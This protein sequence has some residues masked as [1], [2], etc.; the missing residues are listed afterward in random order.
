MTRS[1]HRV[2]AFLSISLLTLV[3]AC[4]ET[5]APPAYPTD[6]VAGSIAAASS[7]QMTGIVGTN[8]ATPPSVIV[9]DESGRP[10]AGATVRFSITAGGGQLSNSTAT[11][12]SQGIA[13]VA[14]WTLG[15]TV[16]SNTVIASLSTL[17]SIRFD[18]VTSPGAVAMILKVAGDDQITARGSVVPVRPQVKVMDAYFNPVKD[19]LVI[20]AIGAGGGSLTGENVTTNSL[21]IA[22]LGSWTLGSS[23]GQTLLAK[24]VELTPVTFQAITFETAEGCETVGAL[25]QQV[26]LVSELS[27]QGCQDGD[28]KFVNYYFVHLAYPAAWEFKLVS[29]VFAP[30]VELRTGNGVPVASG[31]SSALTKN[32]EINAILP[33]GDFI[34]VATS[35]EANATGRY[36]ISYEA[37]SSDAGECE[38]SIGRGIEIS[39]N[40]STASCPLVNEVRVDRYRIYISAGSSVSIVLDDY[41]LND[42]RLR[43]ENDQ[44]QSVAYGIAHDYVESTLDYTA[45]VD[46]YYTIII[47]GTSQ[48]GLV[49]R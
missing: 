13:T 9:K 19:V 5:S 44:G 26:T 31:R 45:R 36:D 25:T 3:S 38:I 40:T 46:G 41:S 4:A 2:A 11:T 23:G 33:A 12:D 49:V 15:T 39:Q 27:G 10:L 28:G 8:V 16:G 21:G 37:G 34:V 6:P 35:L 43:I 48:Y 7:V 17:P 24:A 20:F 14:A 1:I 18:V 42:N 47:E 32:S 30:K 22:T 29:D